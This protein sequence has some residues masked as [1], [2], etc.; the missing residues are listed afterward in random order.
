MS[1]RRHRP[2]VIRRRD[3][4]AALESAVRQEIVDTIQA[5]GPRSAA[6]IATLMGRPADALYYHLR[7]LTRVGILVQR[8]P[9]RA[10]G[11]DEAIYDLVGHPL[12]LDYPLPGTDPHPVPRLV[13]SMLRTAEK[14]FRAAVT[15]DQARPDGELRNLWA[16]RRHAWLG[17]RDLD[18]VNT[19]IDRLVEIMT[20]ART[21]G[22]GQL[23]TLTLVM[24]PR[25][26]RSGR[27][28]PARP[29][30]RKAR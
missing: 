27:R 26:A 13:R 12:V 24:A 6:E 29:A 25:P 14:D 7:R 15:S 1:S 16:G 20:R 9:R 22:S 19:L 3:Q 23:C 5:A 4:I 18:R 10:G 21:P 28:A 17:P 11:R 2:F 30:G 8:V